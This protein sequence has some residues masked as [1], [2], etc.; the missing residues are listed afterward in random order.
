MIRKMR[1]QP[2]YASICVV[3]K[4]PNAI[5][6]NY[7]YFTPTPSDWTSPRTD[8][9]PSAEKIS[10]KARASLHEFWIIIADFVTSE[11]AGGDIYVYS[12][13]LWQYFAVFILCGVIYVFLTGCDWCPDQLTSGCLWFCSPPRP[14]ISEVTNRNLRSTSLSLIS[15]CKPKWFL[16]CSV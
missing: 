7:H 5:N 13:N 16:N 10:S 8:L 3:R 14:L 15:P 2:A 1:G 11:K 6:H 4:C 12:A 9:S